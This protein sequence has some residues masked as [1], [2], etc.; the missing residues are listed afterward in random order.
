[1]SDPNDTV[2]SAYARVYSATGATPTS[3]KSIATVTGLPYSTVT[4][5]LR[6][7]AGEDKVTQSKDGSRMMWAR[8]SVAVPTTAEEDA[9]EFLGGVQ[10]LLAPVK[11]KRTRKPKA[12]EPAPVEEPADVVIPGPVVVDATP[13]A[14]VVAAHKIDAAVTALDGQKIESLKRDALIFLCKDMGVATNPK[15]TKAKLIEKV[16]ARIAEHEQAKRDAA[17]PDFAGMSTKDLKAAAKDLGVKGAVSKMARPALLAACEAQYDV[18]QE[19]TPDAETPHADAESDADAPVTPDGPWG[20]GDAGDAPSGSVSAVLADLQATRPVSAPP[21]QSA[22]P[23]RTSNRPAGG[24]V[25]SGTAPAWTRGQCEATL[26]GM[27]QAE[28]DKEHSATTL[29]KQYNET[30]EDGTPIMQP[31][32]T[33]FALDAM[34]KKGTARLTQDKPKRYAAMAVPLPAA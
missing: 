2:I 1:M 22:T 5:N 9:A 26:L 6:K 25:S 29:V 10:E 32:S 21:A 33:A 3:A 14:D 27:L 24:V 16:N 11:A 19:T 12:A 18:N 34:V 23:R 30:R 31:G 17:R 7:L 15:D 20:T 13:A 28:P 8:T 4:E